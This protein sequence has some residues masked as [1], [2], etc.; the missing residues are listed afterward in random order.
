[1]SPEC[2]RKEEPLTCSFCASWLESKTYTNIPSPC[3]CNCSAMED[4]SGPVKHFASSMDCPI[5]VAQHQ[6]IIENTELSA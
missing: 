1:M 5:M 4:R 3:C 2:S 6:W